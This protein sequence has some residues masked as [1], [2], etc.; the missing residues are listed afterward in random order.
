VRLVK[1]SR[2]PLDDPVKAAFAWRRYKRLMKFMVAVTMGTVVAALILLSRL[3]EQATA[4]FYIATGL[5]IAASMLL[6]SALMGLVF[7]SNGTGHDA[8][9]ADPLDDER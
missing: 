6:M 4:H 9:V 5:G 1:P 7:L 8:S 2:S 3:V